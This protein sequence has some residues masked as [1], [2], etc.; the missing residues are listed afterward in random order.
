MHPVP[1][2]N[3]QA[4]PVKLMDLRL[5]SWQRE[6][7]SIST[8][9]QVLPESVLSAA[10]T[11]GDSYLMPASIQHRRLLPPKDSRTPEQSLPSILSTQ[12]VVSSQCS[13]EFSFMNHTIEFSAYSSP[14]L[15]LV[16]FESSSQR[17]PE[18]QWH[19]DQPDRRY[20]MSCSH[21][22]SEVRG[23]SHQSMAWAA[24]AVTRASRPFADVSASS[25]LQFWLGSKRVAFLSHHAARRE[26]YP[27]LS[28][29]YKI[30]HL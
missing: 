14:S 25:R 24:S 5:P 7:D 30:Y 22:L 8:G 4:D 26:A 10:G 11:L 20:A 6:T 21:R 3:G 16:S 17:L 28:F 19:R 9:G 13:C 29:G 15:L 2:A 23:I 27:S 18:S 1:T 12:A